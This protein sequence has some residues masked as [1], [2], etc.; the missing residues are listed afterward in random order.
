MNK[1]L[2]IQKLLARISTALG[3]ALRLDNAHILLHAFSRV[4]KPCLGSILFLQGDFEY[5][6]FNLLCF[7][8][9]ALGGPSYSKLLGFGSAA[10]KY[11]QANI[12]QLTYLGS[13]P[14]SCVAQINKDFS[15]IDP[16]GHWD[17]C[18]KTPQGQNNFCTAMG[19]EAWGFLPW[20]ILN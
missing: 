1:M 12:L 5:C 10:Y 4:A 3:C 15:F 19:V 9:I 16:G 7:D 11:L 17:N 6:C 20:S 8:A 13:T 18:S 2:K 14:R